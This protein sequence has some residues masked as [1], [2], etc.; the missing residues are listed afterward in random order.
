MFQES[1]IAITR[2]LELRNREVKT[3]VSSRCLTFDGDIPLQVLMKQRLLIRISDKM[4]LVKVQSRSHFALLSPVTL[5]SH[6]LL[7]PN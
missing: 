6:P 3:A 1:N 5:R 4:V 2:S 7:L